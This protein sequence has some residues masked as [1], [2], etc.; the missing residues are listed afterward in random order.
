MR[1]LYI[2]VNICV[3]IRIHVLLIAPRPLPKLIQVPDS[4]KVKTLKKSNKSSGQ[5][6]H[7][8]KTYI[9]Y[10]DQSE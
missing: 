10:I 3:N 4:T 2:W 8:V 9:F 6:K 7:Y 1:I 5:W